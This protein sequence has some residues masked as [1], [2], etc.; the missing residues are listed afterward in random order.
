MYYITERGIFSEDDFLRKKLNSESAVYE[1]VR[2]KEGVALFLVDH[3]LR[4]NASLKS[5]GFDE[6]WNF[7]EFKEKVETLIAVN[8]KSE[9]NIKIVFLPGSHEP[10]QLFAFIPHSYPTSEMYL[11]GVSV[12]LLFAERKNP[13]AKVIQSSV[14]ERANQMIQEQRLYEVL[15]V[16]REG[17]VTEGSRSNVFFVKGDIF[18]TAPASKVLVG[19]TR[20]K[21]IECL[22]ELNF[23][24]VECAVSA[25][26]IGDFDAVFLTGTSP[27]VLPVDR[28]EDC[29][30]RTD[31]PAVAQLMERYDQ[32]IEA[33]IRQEKA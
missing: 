1:V 26:A 28:V 14:R 30:F 21:V 27:K 33:Y 29:I 32:M 31:L 24:L 18:Y 20:T 3:F 13:N 19:I 10:N 17:A 5:K 22:R 12:G 6:V 15:L 11:H 8:Q 2:V 4:M 25:Q 9:G 7:P 23:E 16:D